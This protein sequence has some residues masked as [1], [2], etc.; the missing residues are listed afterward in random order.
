MDAIL[1]T[2]FQESNNTMASLTI[3]IELENFVITSSE[4][5]AT[6]ITAYG[7][8]TESNVRCRV[9]AKPTHHFHGHDK[10]RHLQ[11]LSVCGKKLI[12]SYQPRR[13]ICDSQSCNDATTTATPCFHHAKSQFT[14]ELENT[15]MLGLINSTIADVSKKYNVTKDDVQGILDRHIS[16]EVDWS[17]FDRLD[18]IGIDEIAIKKGRKDF[19]SVITALNNS[20]VTILG[21]VLGRKKR[22]IKRFL[23]SIPTRLKKTVTAVCV[24]MYDGYVNAAKAVFKNRATVIVDRY[25]VA[26]LYRK[27]LDK[28]RKSV[29]NELKQQLSSRD[30]EKIKNVTNLLRAHKEFFTDEEKEKLN[31][32]FSYSP[33]LLE[34]YRLIRKLTHIFNTH[35]TSDEGLIRFN[36]WIA[37]V[38]KSKLSFLKTFLKTL[39]KYKNQ[40]ANYFI[41]R[42]TSGFVEGFNNKLKVL[43][44][45]CYGILNLKHLFQRLVLDTV[46]Y[47][48]YASI[49]V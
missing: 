44:R 17:R 27:S 29:I 37:E 49:A 13:Y 32:L 30:Y 7:Q 36:E 33:E 10:I 6:N 20:K 19:V 28:F 47:E 43:K 42:Q 11:H 14:Y 23:K 40:I 4:E 2:I 35:M 26:K 16:G 45:R 3:N 15:L 24:D 41:N 9:C 31:E 38:N 12:L 25:H 22:D 18:V 5:D 34:A 8:T 46:G 21:V 39:N 48:L 1:T